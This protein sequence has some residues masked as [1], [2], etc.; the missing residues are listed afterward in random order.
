[1]RKKSLFAVPVAWDELEPTAAEL[2][3]IEA[4]MPAIL[5]DVAALDAQMDWLD[6]SDAEIERL[7]LVAALSELTVRRNR[8]RS[9]QLIART[10]RAAQRGSGRV[11]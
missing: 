9:R 6:A 7:D 10:A 1:M 8:R 11:A 4:E 3:A 2:A 5:A